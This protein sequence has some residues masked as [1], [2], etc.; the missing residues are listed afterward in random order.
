M[1]HGSRPGPVLGTIGSARPGPM[2]THTHTHTY[3][4]TR[5]RTRTHT[6]THARTRARTHAPT[7]TQVTDLKG[8]VAGGSI[9]CGVLRK[10]AE[11]E[12]RPGPPHM[13]IYNIC[14]YIYI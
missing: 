6:R 14:I 5:T 1:P 2:H 4:H 8:G 11:I 9:L 10:S 12:I 3:A 7:H 13:F